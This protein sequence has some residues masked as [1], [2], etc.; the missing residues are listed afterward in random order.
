MHKAATE[1]RYWERNMMSICHQKLLKLIRKL[2]H[3]ILSESLQS[4]LEFKFNQPCVA[5]KEAC[6]PK[7]CQW[8]AHWCSWVIFKGVMNWEI[9]FSLMFRGHCTIKT[10][11]EL[12]TSLLLQKQLLLKPSSENNSFQILSHYDI[13]MWRKPAS[14]ESDQRL[15]LHH[16]AL[17]P[18]PGHL[19]QGGIW[20]SRERHKSR[21]VC[22]RGEGGGGFICDRVQLLTL[23]KAC[24]SLSYVS[25]FITFTF[26]IVHIQQ[27]GERMESGEHSNSFGGGGAWPANAPPP[28]RRPCFSPAHWSISGM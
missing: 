9:K 15:L 10:S 13:M 19:Y 17:S 28:W 24:N 18:V 8:L 20:M 4:A 16:H 23:A 21:C 11:S 2:K 12:K 7:K 25:C 5:K 6:L 22:D 27:G 3:L 26:E 1:S 14:A